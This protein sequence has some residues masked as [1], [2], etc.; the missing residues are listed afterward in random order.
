MRCASVRALRS[1]SCY[2]GPV[3]EMPQRGDGMEFG[4]LFTSHPHHAREPYPHR[5]VHAR[6]TAEIQAADT[7]GY[8]TAWV[9]EHHFSN[10]Y[11]IM[12]DVF[13]YMG[14]L[15][16]K[17]SRIRLG[18]AVVT[19]PLYEPVRVVENLAFVDI[20]SGG[21]V[22]IGLGSGYRPY[23][24]AGF[25]RDFEDRRDRQEEAIELILELLHTRRVTHQGRYFRATVAGEY[26][27]FPV[28]IQQPHPPLFMAAGTDRSMA[29]AARHGFGLMLST[30]PSI[31]TLARQVGFYREHVKAVSPPLDQNPACGKVDVA[32]WVYV[33]ETDEAAKRD[34]EADIVRHIS[35]FMSSAT[36]G[37]LGNVSEKHRIDTLNYD[38][39]AATTLVHG[40][41]ETVIA[42]LRALRDQTALTSLLLHYP[43][44]Y[45]HEKTMQS[46]RLFAERVM[47]VF[48]PT[49]QGGGV[50]RVTGTS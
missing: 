7:L 10:Q 48:R 1:E 46:L 23:E 21:R 40:S 37:Y 29:Y 16:A 28:S 31:E 32:R 42:Q 3:Y 12:P 8:D 20:L 49:T 50:T 36:S 14:Y 30:L 15:A 13:T 39:L 27:V 45:G 35:H 26:E 11:G 22:M 47:P 25:G 41:P 6:V 19:V 2:E 18:T 43:P 34:T 33:A 5:E 24:F 9:A 44:S 17:T 4:I 38:T